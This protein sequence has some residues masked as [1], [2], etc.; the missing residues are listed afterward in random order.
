[1][2][3]RE[4]GLAALNHKNAD[5]VPIHDSP[6]GATVNRWRKEGLPEDMSPDEYFGYEIASYGADLTPRF[7]V[8]VIERT[9]EYIITTTQQGGKMKNHRDCTTTPEIID[10]PV[11]TKD[12][13][14]EIKKRLKPDF[15]RV[16]WASGLSRNQREYDEGKFTCF[17]A[18][19]GY[20]A[21]RLYMN[22]EQLLATIAE[23]TDWVKD[24]VT[25]LAENIIVTAE[26]MLMNGYKFDG[27][28][29]YNDL[30]Y[31]NGL[32]FSPDSY[33]KTHYDADRLLYAYFHSRGMKT[34]LHSCGNV[35]A[36]IPTLIEVGLDCLQPLEVK[37]GMDLVNLKAKHGDRIAFMGGID[38]RLMADEDP[39]KIEEEIKTKIVAAKTDGGYIYHS[40]HSIPNNVSFQQYCRVMEL[41]KKYGEYHAPAE[42]PSAIPAVP[43][44]A[45]MPAMVQ[46]PA[47][48]AAEAPKKKGFKLPFGKK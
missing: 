10:C 16:D 12:D 18:A 45:E 9:E 29:L 23:D 43:A 36:L 24:M 6:L 31:K 19:C 44:P 30:G 47:Q 39:A 25:T 1:M 3:S 27:A 32:L 37:E 20:D 34:L 46:K 28:F 17:S 8:K 38:V 5:R 22:S 40:D 33:Q 7:P 14:K 35:S 11:K 15:K 2:T 48:P 42:T 21:L 41:V 26:L 13:W 4:R